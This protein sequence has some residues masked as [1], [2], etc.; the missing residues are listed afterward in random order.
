VPRYACE[1]MT[2]WCTKLVTLGRSA[3]EDGTRASFGSG[4]WGME[5]RKG[6]EVGK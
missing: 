5:R 4:G 6:V 1:G 2:L 3:A